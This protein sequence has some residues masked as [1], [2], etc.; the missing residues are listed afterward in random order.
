[1]KSYRRKN[2][3]FGDSPEEKKAFDFLSLLE[4][5]QAEFVSTLVNRHLKSNGVDSIEHMTSDEAIEISKKFDTDITDEKIMGKSVKYLLNHGMCIAPKDSSEKSKKDEPPE[6]LPD[7]NP[8][9]KTETDSKPKNEDEVISE[10][11]PEEVIDTDSVDEIKDEDAESVL[12]A[13]QAFKF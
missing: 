8:K 6:V 12:S 7:T 5:H 13:L 9:T 11:V 2:L 1:M 4:R 3:A 10:N